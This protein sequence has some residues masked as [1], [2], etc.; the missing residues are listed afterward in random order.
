ME[1]FKRKAN[2][3]MDCLRRVWG[4]KVLGQVLTPMVRQLSEM[5][6]VWFTCFQPGEWTKC[7]CGSS[8]KD[9]KTME[10]KQKVFMLR[11]KRKKKKTSKEFCRA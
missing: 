6:P 8:Q 10:I 4:L 9:R 11:K 1:A 2:M 5:I 7:L 3:R